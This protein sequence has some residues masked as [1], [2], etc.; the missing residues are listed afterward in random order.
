MIN[1]LISLYQLISN[2]LILLISNQINKKSL[3]KQY[4]K[5]NIVYFDIGA[6]LGSN[7][8]LIK[9]L[10]GNKSKIHCFEPNE[11]CAN[12]LKLIPEIKVNN[13][14]IDKNNT[15][16]NFYEH[17]ISSFSSLSKIEGYKKKYK[18]KCVTLDSYINSQNIKKIDYLKIDTE[19][20]DLN[21]LLSAK[22]SI[23]RK[24]IALI[25]TEISFN[26]NGNFTNRNFDNI[27]SFLK[28]N[29]Y[30]LIGIN[31]QKIKNNKILYMNA[32][33]ILKK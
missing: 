20:N 33:F 23:A 12:I 18:V 2:A 8:K 26:H 15:T 24:K 4:F 7:I 17:S 1:K 19:G 13:Y 25:E 3:L 14:A 10:Y 22:K 29:N 5:N 30:F 6:N 16:K 27:Y 11:N 32:L 28:K 21:V 31:D 9:K